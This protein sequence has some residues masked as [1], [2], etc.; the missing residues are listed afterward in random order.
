MEAERVVLEGF[1]A[2]T[3]IF[4]TAL[5]IVIDWAAAKGRL[6]RNHFVGIRTP[7][8]MSSD[9]AWIAG[10]RAALRLT[11]L[12]LVTGVSLLIGVFSART[13]AGLN[14]VGVGGAIVFVA[15]AVFTGIVAARAA[16]AAED[17]PGH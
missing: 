16:K 8:T 14:L 11:P 1:I 12:H 5:L 17:G 15:V 9:R 4:L 6:G 3:F 2:V 13:V 7:S 10:H